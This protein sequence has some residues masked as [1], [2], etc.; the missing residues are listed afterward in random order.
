VPLA[1]TLIVRREDIPAVLSD[2]D[3]RIL[4]R[5]YD[6]NSPQGGQIFFFA[7]CDEVRRALRIGAK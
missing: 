2:T 5:H 3:R 4:R 1:S 6:A 7:D